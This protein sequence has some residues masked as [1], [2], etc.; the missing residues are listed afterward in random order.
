M[1][2]LLK[3]LIVTVMASALLAGCG[4]KEVSFN[5]S[6]LGN[7]LLTGIT[8]Q[9]ELGMMDTQMASMFINLSDVNV[10]NGAVYEGSGATAEEIVV[11]ECATDEDA[12]KAKAALEER[13]SEQKDSFT[14]YVPEELTKL[15]DSVIV[16]TGKYAILSVSN[17]SAT[18]KSI[19]DKYTK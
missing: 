8:Y 13:V 17:D 5:V 11:L 6:D 4:G 12:T 1:K 2:K 16:V 7:D 10:V 18:A 9:D 15:N 14:D 3:T 19:I